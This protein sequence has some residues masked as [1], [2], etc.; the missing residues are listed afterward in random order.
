MIRKLHLFIDF[1]V[2]VD[3]LA[4]YLLNKPVK[5]SIVVSNN[6]RFQS[7]Y[8]PAIAVTTISRFAKTTFIQA[9][10]DSSVLSA[11]EQPPESTQTQEEKEPA[12]NE[13]YEL[14]R[15][16]RAWAAKDPEAALAAAMKLSEGEEHNQALSA[17]C[18]GMAETNPASAVQMAQT[19]HLGD[20]PGAVMESLVQQWAA[21]DLSSALDWANRQPASK[22]RDELT[23]RIAFVMSQSDPEDAANLVIDQISPGPAQ[24]EAVMTVLN[25]WANHNL[26]AAT[27]W[28][29]QFP[30]SPLQV[31]AVNELKGIAQHQKAL[32][33]Q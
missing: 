32:A 30:E 18:L 23:T 12:E 19:L 7:V 2:V 29:T 24:N 22:Q 8:H 15:N 13:K 1:C 33:Q 10:A 11:T 25:Q 28:V 20:G 14:L 27:A 26:V 31:R 5:K 3:I 6:T 16:L 9:E 17:V 4:V 21:T